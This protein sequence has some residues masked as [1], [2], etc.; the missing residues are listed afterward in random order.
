MDEVEVAGVELKGQPN[1][2]E[3][4]KNGNWQEKRNIKKKKNNKSFWKKR[5]WNIKT[6]KREIFNL[7]IK[8]NRMAENGRAK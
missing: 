6:P 8:E 3:K 4:G 2:N 5:G 1:P 7:T